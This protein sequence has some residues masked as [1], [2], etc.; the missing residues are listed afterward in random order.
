MKIHFARRNQL[1]RLRPAASLFSERAR[2][3]KGIRPELCPAI[4]AFHCQGW[5]IATPVELEFQGS[6]RFRV[7][8]FKD[9]S[10]GLFLSPGV[11]GTPET[12][13]LYA[14][15]DTGISITQSPVPLL[16]IRLQDAKFPF[17][18]LHVPATL[19]PPGYVGP[20]LIPMSSDIGL[21]VPA[22]ALILHVI[23]QYPDAVD[24]VIE[25]A[26]VK[27]EE[28]EGLYDFGWP[29]L[30]SLDQ[31]VWSDEFLLEA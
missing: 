12:E 18:C 21:V 4:R 26:D 13:R 1:A 8:K 5:V 19:Y 20:I 27:H 10:G 25:E 2:G 6:R 31:R 29:D 22:G 7:H 14:R 17:P 16:A 23:P 30:F 11:I 24:A 15:V 28:F 3:V 9:Q